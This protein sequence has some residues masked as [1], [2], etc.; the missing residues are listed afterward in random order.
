MA[1]ENL[2]FDES[3]ELIYQKHEMYKMFQTYTQDNLIDSFVGVF[4]D[5]MDCTYDVNFE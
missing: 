2:V 5:I 4:D 3:G 1:L